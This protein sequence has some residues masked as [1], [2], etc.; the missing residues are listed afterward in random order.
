MCNYENPTL[1]NMGFLDVGVYTTSGII[2]NTRFFEVQNFD[3]E[4]FKDNLDEMKKY[5]ENKEIKFIVYA[6][7]GN[8]E[9]PP[10]YIYNNYKQVYKDNY[11]FEGNDS[12]AYLFELKN[13]EK[14]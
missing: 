5:V 6:S 11:I 9:Q 12:T 8:N 4:K 1:L 7:F 10:E 3:Y 2:P 14:K 13:L